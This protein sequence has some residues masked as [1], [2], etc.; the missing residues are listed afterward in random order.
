M[1]QPSDKEY[2]ATKKIMLGLATMDP[3]FIGLADFIDKTFNVKTINIIYDTID[4]GQHPRL[5]ICFEFDREKQSFYEDGD[6]VYAP[7]DKDKQ[8]IIAFKF[9][10]LMTN[11]GIVKKKSLLDSLFTS[12]RNKYK[13]NDVWICYSAFEGIAKCEANDNV[14]NERV[15]A[16]KE[17]LNCKELWHIVKMSS[18]TTFFV[19]TDE[20][21]EK[22]KNSEIR[23]QWTAKYFDLLVVYN[24]FNYFKPEEFSIG[25][26]SKKNFDINYGGSWYN[27]FS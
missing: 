10:E 26:D 6:A 7:F 13:V 16:L 11:N 4:K 14:P 15:A 20:Q 17:E 12:H 2:K 3:D 22:F 5:N 19:Y 18:G 23:K 27:Y 21:L 9:K 1:I 8:E 24:E 25:L